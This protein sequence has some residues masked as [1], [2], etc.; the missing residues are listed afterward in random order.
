MLGRQL[1]RLSGRPPKAIQTGSLLPTGAFFVFLS[2]FTLHLHGSTF[3][4]RNLKEKVGTKFYM[5]GARYIQYRV[6]SI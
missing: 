2:F 3:V 6:N 1:L 5:M 4:I